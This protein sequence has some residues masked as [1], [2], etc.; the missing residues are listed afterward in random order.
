MSPQIAIREQ[1][2]DSQVPGWVL[3]PET[4]DRNHV[5]FGAPLSFP[6]KQPRAQRLLLQ[7]RDSVSGKLYTP[8]SSSTNEE[9]KV[10]QERVDL[11][12]YT[13]KIERWALAFDEETATHSDK[14][15]TTLYD[16]D[17]F[18]AQELQK[19]LP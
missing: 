1:H 13:K 3:N 8:T 9:A 4:F 6:N 2:I 17:Y 11:F 14:D 16:E 15:L 12:E 18:E 5:T 10:P 19:Q 7:E